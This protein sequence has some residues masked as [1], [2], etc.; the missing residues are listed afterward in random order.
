LHLRR[1]GIQGEWELQA[2]SG[3][4]GEGINDIGENMQKEERTILSEIKTVHE[5]MVEKAFDSGVRAGFWAGCVTGAAVVLGLS[6]LLW[7]LR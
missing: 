4:V 2:Q 1:C 6:L 5:M 3:I 7:R